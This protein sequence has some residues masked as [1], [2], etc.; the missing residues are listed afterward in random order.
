MIN[1][2]LFGSFFVL[3]FL[4]VPICVSLG[5]SSVF[6]MLYSGDKIVSID[7]KSVV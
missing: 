7:R 6:A 5:M 2:I 1:F 4:N 3:L